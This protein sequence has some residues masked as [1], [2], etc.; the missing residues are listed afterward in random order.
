M[1]CA[2]LFCSRDTGGWNRYLDQAPPKLS[3]VLRVLTPSERATPKRGARADAAGDE[4]VC[5]DSFE[6]QPYVAARERYD[7]LLSDG[8]MFGRRLIGA[9]DEGSWRRPIDSL[10]QAAAIARDYNFYDRAELGRAAAHVAQRISAKLQSGAEAHYWESNLST[11]MDDVGYFVDT[12][13][14]DGIAIPEKPLSDLLRASHKE[15]ARIYTQ[16]NRPRR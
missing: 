14:A 8:T 5:A 10:K 9:P 7:E 2:D 12:L 6:H 15:A 13:S 3:D 4:Y 16:A 1:L 11:L